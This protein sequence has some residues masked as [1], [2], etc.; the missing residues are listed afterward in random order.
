[1]ED[2]KI[3][4]LFFDRSESA[5]SELDT[6][7]GKYCLQLSHNIL[8]NFQDAEEC[9]N[10][11]Y[12]GIWNTVPPTYPNPLLTF[13]CKVVR[14]LSL[15]KY[16]ANKALKRNSIYDVA[17]GELEGCL[18]SAGTV[19]EE[20][21]A[22]ELARSIEA[23][24]DTLSEENRVIFMRRHWFSDSYEDIAAKVGLSEKTVSVRLVR[25]RKQLR[26]YLEKRGVAV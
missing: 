9:V 11:A 25:I 5:I 2:D 17:L 1:M 24:M 14:N 16:H 10:D 8:K 12:L 13:L 15:K 19:E 26:K 18:V 21:A 20:V 3:I 22:K 4:K 7:Y 23:F 6:K